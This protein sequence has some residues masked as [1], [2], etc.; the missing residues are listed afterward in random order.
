MILHENLL[1]TT[2]I[3]ICN[4]DTYQSKENDTETQSKRKPNDK[5]TQTNPI[6]EGEEGKESKEDKED[7]F[8][9]TNFLLE[10]MAES[11]LIK[12]WFVVRK[13]KKLSNTKTA[14]EDFV[15]EVKK[16]EVNINDVLKKCIISSWGGFKYSWILNENKKNP[17]QP[18]STSQYSKLDP[19]KIYD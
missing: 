18:Q 5:Q 8:N 17:I 6:E 3:T 9:P 19:N 14:M 13:N 7:K 15:N 16:S 2:R 4:Y 1:K 11:D 10:N 12:Q